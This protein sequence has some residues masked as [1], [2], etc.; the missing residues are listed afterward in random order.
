MQD[1]N[2]E[3]SYSQSESRFADIRATRAERASVKQQK[4][5]DAAPTHPESYE[6]DD[7]TYYENR[8]RAYYEPKPKRGF[9]RVMVTQLVLCAL[10]LG[11]LAGAKRIAPN[12]FRQIKAAYTQMMRTD[13]SV[14]EVWAAIKV[15]AENLKEEIYVSVP[16]KGVA[17]ERTTAPAT[18]T[19]IPEETTADDT[20]PADVAEEDDPHV[21][22]MGAG[23]LDISQTLAQLRCT[24][25][26]IRTT[27]A[28]MPPL[29]AGRLT[30]SFGV[31]THPITKEADSFH[32]G[33]DIAAPQGTPIHAAFF[34]VVETV[35]ESEY[36]G[37]YVLIKHSDVLYS[38][39]GHCAEVLAQEGM[40]VRAGECVALVGSTGLSTGPHLHFEIR[41]N[42]V[43]CDPAA[44]LD[45]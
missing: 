43:R 12:S 20:P 19:A 16:A 21:E 5:A 4:K 2:R 32:T 13:M 15:M 27:I 10:L 17:D 33:V 40:V 9:I 30:S 23:G 31:R 22:D 6:D 1:Y 39:Y 24:L 11:G 45:I 26:P 35:G 29:E 38:F 41:L 18:T 37:N 14:G 7:D 28:P 36:Y 3:L 34:G 8:Y 25:S 42:G 44:L